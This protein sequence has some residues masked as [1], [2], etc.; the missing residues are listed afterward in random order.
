[1]TSAIEVGLG[2]ISAQGVSADRAESHAALVSTLELCRYAEQVGLD[3]VWA[4]EHH[5]TADGYLPSPLTLL[6]AV[7][8]VTERI[9]LSTNVLIAPLYSPVRLA[10]DAGVIDQL[11]CGRLMLGLGLGYRESEF[12]GLK[13]P[14]GHRAEQLE[15]ALTVLRA[16]SRGIALGELDGFADDT[17]SITPL[18]YDETGPELLVGAFAEVGIRRARRLADGWIAPELAHPRQ[19]E[20]R[21]AMLDLDSLDRPFH[22]ALTMNAFTA[23][24]DAWSIVKP[25]NELV[26]RQYRAWL[27]AS[28]DLPQLNGKGFDSD[29]ATDGRPPQFVAGTPDECIEQ[30]RPWWQVLQALPPSVTAHLTLRMSFPGVTDEATRESV[31]MLAQEI[32]PALRD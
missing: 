12:R 27:T 3:S 22:I 6:A 15:A 7:A 30:L 26:A 19:L 29:S 5:F 18:P 16:A 4:S 31:R 21:L 20:K 24:R 2:A 17:P 23:A 10:E 28:G 11:S 13:I 14:L 25:G 9:R 1:M 32:V 8:G